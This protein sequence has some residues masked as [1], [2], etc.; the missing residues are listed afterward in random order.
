MEN[1]YHLVTSQHWLLHEP[2]NLQYLIIL[3]IGYCS[4]AAKVL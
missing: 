4:Y 3:E 2:L 1:N